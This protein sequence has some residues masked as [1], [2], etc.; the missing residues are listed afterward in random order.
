MLATSSQRLRFWKGFSPW[1]FIWRFWIGKSPKKATVRF[2]G[3]FAIE[4]MKGIERCLT[5][6]F[7]QTS[8]CRLPSPSCCFFPVLFLDALSHRNLW[9][10]ASAD[11]LKDWYDS[12]FQTKTDR[13]RWN[14]GRLAVAHS[15]RYGS[16]D[17]RSG[18]LQSHFAK[19]QML[20][21]SRE[22]HRQTK[23]RILGL[24]PRSVQFR[25]KGKILKE[26]GSVLARLLN[27]AILR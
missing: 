1:L 12:L 6:N 10:F 11:K 24:L 18:G 21:R 19:R 7:L 22:M 13:W 17:F 14:A 25:G 20:W 4:L 23:T 2:R 5:K 27:N 15:M 3:N 9:T 26:N 8:W 16:W